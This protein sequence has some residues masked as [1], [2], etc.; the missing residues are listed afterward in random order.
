MARSAVRGGDLLMTITGYIGRTCRYPIDWPEANI[1]QHIARIRIRDR[2]ILAPEFAL[3]ALKHPGVLRALELEVTGLAYPQIGLTQVQ[4]IRIH[5]PRLERQ[6]EIAAA[7]DGQQAELK[8]CEGQLA[9]L[10]AIKRGLS[11]DLLTG[12]V[13]VP[14]ELELA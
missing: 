4:N 13:R 10:N 7:L 5:A 6:I 1:N 14:S 8:A 3:W 12:R 2:D 9:K 11:D